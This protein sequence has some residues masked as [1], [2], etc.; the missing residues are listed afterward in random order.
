MHGISETFFGTFIYFY[1]RYSEV[2]WNFMI[3]K[4]KK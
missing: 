2:K 1:F 3:L 4:P